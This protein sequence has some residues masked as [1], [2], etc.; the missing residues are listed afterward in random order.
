MSKTRKKSHLVIFQPSGKRGSIAEGQSLLEAA[1]QLGVDLESVC[2]GHTTCGKCLV[3]IE[4]GFFEKEGIRS[5]M[6]A[7]SP[8][9]EKE[10][11]LIQSK[12]KSGKYR[13]ACAARVYGDVLVFVPEESRK[14]GQVVRKV[15][16][17]RLA[18]I[19][20]AVKN[21]Y[22]ELTAPT[23]HNSG[24]DWERLSS[25]LQNRHGLSHLTIDHAA[26]ANLPRT[27]RRGK[28]QVTV[29]VWQGKEVIKVNEGHAE[30]SFGLAVDIGT[31]T[32][33]GYLCDLTS[34]EVVATEFMMN[35]QIAYGE[36]V[37]SRIT[38]TVVNRNGLSKLHKAIVGAI[39]QIARQVAARVG[40]G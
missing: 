40:I 36:D 21:Y 25:E 2:G 18:A 13:L 17:A 22:L 24:A 14:T 7:L 20:P 9:E 33:A 26:L 11:E 28:W 32:L 1:Q 39:N 38:Y 27:L 8:M 6:T 12:H 19:N 5:A 37:I 23:L 4:E 35:P 30:H 10:R 29:S 31:T 3:R 16:A 34:G 15:F